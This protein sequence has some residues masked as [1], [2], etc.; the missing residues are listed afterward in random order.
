MGRI[1]DTIQNLPTSNGNGAHIAE[2]AVVKAADKHDRQ[3]DDAIN[4]SV[5]VDLP[6]FWGNRLWGVGGYENTLPGIDRVE[7]QGYLSILRTHPQNAIFQAGYLAFYRQIGGT[8]YEVS[9]KQRAEWYQNVFNN[10]DRGRGWASLLNKILWDYTTLD[11]GAVMEIIGRGEPD[12]YL[13]RKNVT[14][15]GYLDS[16]RC[17]FTDNFEYPVFYQDYYGKLHKMHHSRVTRFVDMP[18]GAQELF[19]RGFCALSRAI[20]W[21]QQSIS[22]MTYTG[23]MLSDSPPAGMLNGGKVLNKTEFRQSYQQ[24]QADRRAA[25]N[26]TYKPIWWN[27]QVGEKMELEFI[28]FTTAPTGYDFEKYTR[29]QAQG[30]AAAL[31]ID[32][33]DILPLVSGNFGTGQESKVLDRKGQGKTLDFLFREFE[34]ILNRAVLP[35]NLE[36]QFKD[37]DSEQSQRET[38]NA[39]MQLEIAT[40]LQGISGVSS[41]AVILYIANTVD[42]FRDVLLD[43]QGNVRVY[44]D[45][46]SQPTIPADVEVEAE[47]E[48]VVTDVQA[49]PAPDAQTVGDQQKQKAIAFKDY[50]DIRKRYTENLYD[51]WQGLNDGSMDRR[52]A[53]IIAR[54]L[55]ARDGRQAYIEGLAQGGVIV[56][57]LEG[58]D[59]DRYNT[60]VIEA[61]GYISNTTENIVKNGMSDDEIRNSAN[62]Y[63]NKTLQKFYYWGIESG[64]RNGL[65]K[66]D[67]SDGKESCKDCRR[68]KGKV[69]RMYEWTA[70]KMRPG[71]D[72]ENFECGGWECD[73]YLA[74]HKGRRSRGSLKSIGFVGDALTDAH[75]RAIR[76][77]RR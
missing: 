40:M 39:K 48:P 73:H 27:T 41:E 59:L 16:R 66:F 36:F 52:R 75:L 42:E 51:A 58:D 13:D 6:A 18:F 37:Q 14:G 5:V 30:V 11:D 33:N 70:A 26:S 45:D 1:D 63:G 62:A 56:D 67:G 74:K 20:A 54:A 77:T 49:T 2:S 61:S 69:Y 43:E 19:G 53:G 47:S 32:P 29:L 46:I 12:S 28:P 71:V 31:G 50:E 25:G 44:D 57:T 68:L 60:L 35:D 15:I 76:Y 17:F 4:Q 9:G 64:D 34:R 23:E 8:G 21:V 55:T 65:Y 24:Y 3:L 72:T 22:A 10:A 7:R 38:E